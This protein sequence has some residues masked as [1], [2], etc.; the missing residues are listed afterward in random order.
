MEDQDLG[1]GR[2]AR[3]QCPRFAAVGLNGTSSS[4]SRRS[5]AQSPAA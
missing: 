5:C 1:L 2:C 3:A 4:I